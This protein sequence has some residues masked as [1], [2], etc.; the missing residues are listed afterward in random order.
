M[1][2]F[3]ETMT[4]PLEK[5]RLA[6][7]QSLLV[8]GMLFASPVWSQTEIWL[9]SGPEC[10]ICSIYEQIASD[11]GYSSHLTIDG[12]DI[13]I[14]RGDKQT[15][16]LLLAEHF[17]QDI[18]DDVNWPIQLTVVVVEGGSV[19]YSAN[20]AES[21]DWSE[22]RIDE[23]HMDP[24]ATETEA[25]LHDYGFDY[26]D[27]FRRKINLEYFVARA[28]GEAELPYREGD[29][30]V[31]D[32]PEK[33]NDKSMSIWGTAVQPAN[34]GLFI[35][36]RIRELID[37]FGR[38][39]LFLTYTNGGD[40]SR[41][42][43]LLL[44]DAGYRF[45]PSNLAADFAGDFAGVD[46]WFGHIASSRADKHLII[47]VGHYGP[48]GMPV[49]GHALKLTPEAIGAAV[50]ATGKDVTLVSGACH[51][52]LLAGAAQCGF[53]AAHPEVI[54]TGCQRS[55]DAIEASD[56]YLMFFFLSDDAPKDANQD[57]TISFREAHWYAAS[58]VER[59]NI[60]YSDIDRRVDAYF[61]D[62]AADLPQQLTLAELRSHVEHLPEAQRS[63]FEAMRTGLD[64]GLTIS[65]T[66]HVAS[67]REA[68][69]RLDGAT[70][71]SSAFRN[72]AG[73]LAYPLSLVPL[74]RQA[75]YLARGNS[76][77]REWMAC[78]D[79]ALSDY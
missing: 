30:R 34:N 17:G 38:D 36:T 12:E 73:G 20:I 57:G 32:A 47:Q 69:E 8:A 53:F 58:R 75:I 61:S 29:I 74:A 9:L 56:D 1:N 67:K 40:R 19:L 66:G 79:Q 48:T 6:R 13:A 28:R 15:L 42:D 60:V 62:H 76:F 50:D 26:A 11:R 24:P 31:E 41:R 49:W 63:A 55:F 37:R 65:L 2:R 77:D 35:S 3:A 7:I 78:G 54:A 59:H 4:Q 23:R 44:D 16:P 45:V 68:L 39:R 27:Y 43:T 52:G 33:V 46:D 5:M 64:D 71:E 18:E 72:R 22:G 51:S 21:V 25:A 70:E 10:N 14:R